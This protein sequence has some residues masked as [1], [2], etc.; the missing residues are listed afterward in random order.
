M[1]TRRHLTPQSVEEMKDRERFD[2]RLAGALIPH[3]HPQRNLLKHPI[4]RDMILQNI[5]EN[6]DPLLRRFI[7]SGA[8]KIPR[9]IYSRAHVRTNVKYGPGPQ[10]QNLIRDFLEKC[11]EEHEVVA[12]RAEVRSRS[13]RIV[14]LLVEVVRRNERLAK[15]FMR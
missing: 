2:E 6:I 15:A 3:G 5:R 7:A 10:L 12:S 4:L 11:Y 14:E 1:A 8:A 9:S 13:R